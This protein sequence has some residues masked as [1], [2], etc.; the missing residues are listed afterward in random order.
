[1]SAIWAPTSP[2]TPVTTK[3]GNYT[4]TGG[5]DTVNVNTGSGAVTITL[6]AAAGLQGHQFT[7]KKI[8]IDVNNV[9]IDP[10][11]AE[12]IDNAANLTFNGYLEAYTFF[13]DGSAWWVR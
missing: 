9:V 2:Y 5:D 8:S 7:V 4:V 12:L 1:M 13:S 6:P 3:T 11:G 10:N